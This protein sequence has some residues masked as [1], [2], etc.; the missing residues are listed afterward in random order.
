LQVLFQN[1]VAAKRESFVYRA[2]SMSRLYI[3]GP[4]EWLLLA[5]A[6]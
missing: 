5:E 1:F 6:V 4:F 2:V 3:V